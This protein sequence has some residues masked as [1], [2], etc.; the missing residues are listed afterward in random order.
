MMKNGSP[1]QQMDTHCRRK[2][3]LR[4]FLQGVAIPVGL[5]TATVVIA[6]ACVQID[7]F[8][9]IA[10][11]RAV[12]EDYRNQTEQL[13]SLSDT[14]LI[15]KF[16][17]LVGLDIQGYRES[18]E[19]MASDFLESAY[20]TA[21]DGSTDAGAAA[22]EQVGGLAR[23]ASSGADNALSKCWRQQY[24]SASIDRGSQPVDEIIPESGECQS[25]AADLDALSIAKGDGEGTLRPNT[26]LETE[27]TRSIYYDDYPVLTV[28]RAD[29][30]WVRDNPQAWYP[31]RYTPDTL[32]LDPEDIGKQSRQQQR[33]AAF[34]AGR[35][36]SYVGDRQFAEQGERLSWYEDTVDASQALGTLSMIYDSFAA[37]PT[38]YLDLLPAKQALQDVT[39]SEIDEAQ[40][41]DRKALLSH[42]ASLQSSVNIIKDE[43]DMRYERLLGVWV[44][45]QQDIPETL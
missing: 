23:T 17:G 1:N 44:S 30:A 15:D 18:V 14:E 22:I 28:L 7:A 11:Y 43:S 41:G 26:A 12:Y 4:Y 13:K 34:L 31:M 6:A 25:K 45:Q 3:A 5:G 36:L 10:D 27:V 38:S 37:Y 19:G 32:E 9:K 24:G 21:L 40:E 42:Y 20:G 39:P 29:L 35:G 8:R 16:G 33:I 2:S